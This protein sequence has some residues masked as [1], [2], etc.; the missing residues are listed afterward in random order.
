MRPAAGVGLEVA[1]ATRM[2][3]VAR[4]LTSLTLP[5]PAVDGVVV[6]TLNNVDR[7]EQLDLLTHAGLGLRLNL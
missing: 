2:A 7:R 4:V 1:V 5:D 6:D 3:L